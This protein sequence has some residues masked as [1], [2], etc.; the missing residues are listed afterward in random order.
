MNK[1]NISIISIVI[2]I[3]LAITWVYLANRFEKMVQEVVLPEIKEYD[4]V[5][6]TN[7]EEVVIDKYMFKL[8]TGKINI[9]TSAN[10]IVKIDG[11]N[12]C[13]NPIF[14]TVK[15]TNIANGAIVIDNK[16]VGV[17]TESKKFTIKFSNELFKNDK[18]EANL[19]FIMKGMT[20]YRLD[21]DEVLSSND[22]A[23]F[24][25][26]FSPSKKYTDN[27]NVL[28]KA[29]ALDTTIKSLNVNSGDKKIDHFVMKIGEIIKLKGN[30]D[31]NIEYELDFKR[32]YIKEYIQVMFKLASQDNPQEIRNIVND[33]KLLDHEFFIEGKENYKFANKDGYDSYLLIKNDGKRMNL[34]INFNI[35]TTPNEDNNEKITKL[36]ADLMYEGAIE[37]SLTYGTRADINPED[38]LGL[39]KIFTD[40]DKLKLAMNL[41]FDYKFTKIAHNISLDINDNAFEFNGKKALNSYKGN[42]KISKPEGLISYISDNLAVR[43]KP[44][45][46][47]S[48][49]SVSNK[50]I[51]WYDAVVQNIKDNG[52]NAIKVFHNKDDLKEG[53]PLIADIKGNLKNYNITFNNKDFFQIMSDERL[54]PLFKNM[55]PA[56]GNNPD[57]SNDK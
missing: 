31:S 28:V 36:F 56:P 14:G 43:L 9:I 2:L 10:N 52:F 23:D 6:E 39:A 46:T 16:N 18:E 38:L 24:S 13:Y 34:D 5:I 26:I 40:V 15:G 55:P 45:F 51:E 42:L 19:F 49:P 21:S 30:V 53:E 11:I 32:K 22:N 54:I 1:K 29:S 17:A 37:D 44:I 47:K 20:V 33:N 7:L 12:F 57:E 4:D 3:I 50:E 35:N 41:N 25:L 8:T 27:L 48:A